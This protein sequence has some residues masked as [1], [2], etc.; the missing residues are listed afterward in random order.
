MT[1]WTQDVLLQKLVTK[2]LVLQFEDW[3]KTRRKKDD[4]RK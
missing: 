1:K 2:N 3:W 4:E